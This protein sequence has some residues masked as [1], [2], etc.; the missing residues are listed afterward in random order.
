MTDIRPFGTG[1]GVAFYW[2]KMR[3]QWGPG[4]LE[5][6]GIDETGTV[7]STT[8]HRDYDEAARTREEA[9]LH[10]LSPAIKQ[11]DADL[12]RR[13]AEQPE[14]P[15]KPAPMDPATRRFYQD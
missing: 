3:E 15:D 14:Q 5:L 8:G 1:E 12:E 9:V 13:R 10:H 11:A 2:I 7:T 4:F 6:V